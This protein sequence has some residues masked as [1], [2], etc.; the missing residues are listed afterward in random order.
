NEDPTAEH[1]AALGRA[2]ATWTELSARAE[3]F[4][5]MSFWESAYGYAPRR[6]VSD[7]LSAIARADPLGWFEA[8]RDGLLATIHQCCALGFVR[9]ATEILEAIRD[10]LVTSN[11]EQQREDATV[12]VLHAARGRDD[13]LAEALG[14]RALTATI[15]GD[16]ASREGLLDDIRSAR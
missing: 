11:G 14:L 6:T 7:E 15:G 2:F 8:E 4:L 16:N 5:P 9:T 3:A 1:H 12:A 10:F 13:K